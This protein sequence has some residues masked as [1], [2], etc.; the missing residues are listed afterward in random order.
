MRFKI[1]KN[2]PWKYQI[3]YATIKLHKADAMLSKSDHILDNKTL[4]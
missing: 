3:N 4:R 1:D 2:L